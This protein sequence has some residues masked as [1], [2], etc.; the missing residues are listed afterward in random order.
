[1][2]VLGVVLAGAA[3]IARNSILSIYDT[4]YEKVASTLGLGALPAAIWL[5]ALLLVAWKRPSWLRRVNLW[6]SS[7]AVLALVIGGMAF[8]EVSDG[9][10]GW[11]TLQGSASLGGVVGEAIVGSTAWLGVLRLI[12][13]FVLAIALAV[14][15]LLVASFSV[16]AARV[17]IYAYLA[18]VVAVKTVFRIGAS[19]APRR[20]PVEASSP[21]PVVTPEPAA[22]HAGFGA[23]GSGAPAVGPIAAEA[24]A[25]HSEP[26]QA[27]ALAASMP[28]GINNAPK[29]IRPF[30]MEHTEKAEEEK[31]EGAAELSEPTASNGAPEDVWPSSIEQAQELEVEKMEGIVEPPEPTA[32]NG[33]PEDVWLSPIKQAQEPEVEKMEGVAE[34]SEPTASN[35]ALEDVWLSPIEQAQEPE[36]EKMEGIAEP[37]EPIEISEAPE[38]VW[39]PAMEQAEEPEVVV[40]DVVEPPEPIEI[41]EAP[42][43]VWLPAM[44]QAEEPEVVVESAAELPEP[45]ATNGTAHSYQPSAAKFN[46]FWI[47]SGSGEVEPDSAPEVQPKEQEYPL[48]AEWARPSIN[49]F[50]NPPEG[51]ITDGEMETTGETI[52]QTL[53]EYGIEIEVEQVRPGPTVTMYGLV[54]GW[55]RRYKQVREVDEEGNRMLDES[56]KPMMKKVESKT[57]VKVDSILSREK[58]LALA[59]KTPSIRIETPVMGES[60]I[61]IEVPNPNPSLVTLRSVMQSAEFKELQKKAQLPVALGRA[62]GGEPVVIDLAKM[63]HLLIAGAT[64][65]GKSVCINTIIS[66]LIMEKTPAEMRLL[67]IDPK[68]VEL[69]PYNGIPHLITPVVV[70]VDQVVGM[71]KG[72]IQEMLDRYRRMEDV[73]VRNIQAYNERMQDKMP[74]VVIA[75]DELA[76]LMMTSAFDAE[77][78]ICRLAQLGRAT[79]IHLIV[80]TQRPSVDVVTGLIKANFPSRIGFGVTSQVD[81][82]TILDS[83]G[84]DKLL[85]RGDML[86]LPI[87]ASRPMRAQGVFISDQEIGGL[88]GFWQSTP[89]AHL[90]R[91]DLRP[92]ESGEGDGEADGSGGEARDELLDKAIELAQSYSK[93][94]TSL[95]QRRMRIG[96]PRAARLMDQLEDQG[97][98]GPSDGS[99]SRDVIIGSTSGN[100]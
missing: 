62:S 30:A 32:S 38:N 88:V 43:N 7:A 28:V 99:K 11:F 69:T 96:Y 16:L 26:E 71:L 34:L 14:P 87:D 41:S 76:D 45:A 90:P 20:R 80:A 29:D 49:L 35:G 66:C 85:G 94:S 40:E 36:V 95:L 83:A 50:S 58:D 2:L 79:G 39:L 25:P 100:I 48:A 52:R 82:R 21:E 54:P 98:V 70:E 51:G 33:A 77:Q 91:I 22:A 44:E 65:S 42:E 6:M 53:A 24:L 64:G 13:I 78:A 68:R 18:F 15:P 86:Y 61:G 74:L 5:I 19:T 37:P 55:I 84:A 10:A 12:G 59:L 46:D 60:L 31:M 57:R 17:M 72:M 1:M 81:S 92:V 73:G 23:M 8:F 4:A 27:A 3:Y 56:G 47:S 89:R 75:I 9:V 67:L 63:P 97:I 93:V